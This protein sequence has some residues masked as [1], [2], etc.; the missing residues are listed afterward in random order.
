MSQTIVDQTLRKLK[1]NNVRI[2]PQRQA[3]LE[4]MIGTHMHP[5]AVMF[6]R[7]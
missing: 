5:T 6:I 4:F 3:V 2:T 7:P 1:A